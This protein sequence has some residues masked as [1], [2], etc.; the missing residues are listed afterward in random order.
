MGI[1]AAPNPNYTTAAT[2]NDKYNPFVPEELRLDPVDQPVFNWMLNNRIG[3]LESFGY[4]T[5]QLQLDL[6]L[7]NHAGLIKT[8]KGNLPPLVVVSSNRSA[9]IQKGLAE[10][11]KIL[12]GRRSFKDVMDLDA[13]IKGSGS[14][15]PPI[16]CPKRVNAPNR[17][18]YVVVHINE[19]ETYRKAL[20][21][22]DIK[23]VGWNFPAAF[24]TRELPF[25]AGFGASRFAAIEFCK[26]LRNK[27]DGVKSAWLF[28]DNV[29][30]MSK[31]FEGLQGTE[32]SLKDGTC[33]VG[34]A[35]LPAP[36]SRPEILK[37]AA[38]GGRAPRKTIVSAFGPVFQQA[39][40]WNINYLIENN[41]NFGITYVASAED[42]SLSRFIKSRDL[43]ASFVDSVVVY[44]E[45]SP[46]DEQNDQ[47]A[48]HV[49]RARNQLETLFAGLESKPT[50]PGKQ[51]PPPV[52][53]LVKNGDGT[54]TAI[55]NFIDNLVTR[56][57]PH[58]S[59]K[60]KCQAAE[61][62]TKTAIGMKFVAAGAL[63]RTF[64]KV[65]AKSEFRDLYA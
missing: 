2:A 35:A 12:S 20:D 57:E 36:S 49:A 3:T 56:Q 65:E 6:A 62:I 18:V 50:E 1:T 26:L 48:Q 30:A 24:S 8:E 10:C 43:Q 33:C 23:I 37:W 17:N 58:L 60:A 21:K 47:G 7:K 32:K 31:P 64:M 14:V 55:A 15:S 11:D 28:D 40:L 25:L 22:H 39:V 38:K 63:E 45:V 52:N 44:K 29:V 46:L 42:V 51:S 41:I 4:Q 13:L 9:W 53:V 61:Q 27:S 54:P 5:S 34:F 16:Y 59:I 19:Y